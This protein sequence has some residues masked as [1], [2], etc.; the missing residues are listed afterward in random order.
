MNKNFKVRIYP[1]QEQQ[2]LIE[3]TF[4]CKRYLYNFMLN[5]K[6]KLYKFY[7]ISLNYNNMSKVL[8]ELKKHKLWLCEVDAIA[9]QQC[10]KDLDIAYQRY[11][12]KISKYPNFKSKRG[13]NSYRTNGRT[14]HLNQNNKK[15]RIPKVDWIKFIIISIYRTVGHTGIAYRILM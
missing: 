15:I 8:T 6:Q 2:A 11:F 13:K 12:D 7:N 14:I 5:L 9:L 1:N 4:G 3:K 10:L